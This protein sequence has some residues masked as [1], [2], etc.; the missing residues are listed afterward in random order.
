MRN[1]PN[2]R[3]RREPE[4]RDSRRPAPDARYDRRQAAGREEEIRR[5]RQK[6]RQM[7]AKHRR[8]EAAFRDAP[9][10]QRTPARPQPRGTM[11]RRLL[12]TGVVVAALLLVF[13]I[14][15]RVG[16]VNVIGNERYLAQTVLDA[17]GIEMGE[18]LLML[19]RFR[20]S[21]RILKE[22]PFVESV[23]IGIKLPDTVN[24][25]IVETQAA[26]CVRSTDGGWWL[27]NANGTLLQ[28]VTQQEGQAYLQVV[29]IQA[30]QPAAGKQ[31][32]AAET[33]VQPSVT[34]PTETAGTEPETEPETEPGTEPDVTAVP[35]ST[36]SQDTP[37]DSALQRTQAALLILQTLE[38]TDQGS[39][40]TEVDVSRLQ[41]LQVSYGDR[42]LV[43]LGG[44][45][46]LAYRTAYMISAVKELPD[47][48]TGILD[49]TFAQQE[50]AVF[51]PK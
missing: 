44:M 17:S 15:L 36:G 45:E 38:Q 47:Y 8:Q 16:Q 5:Q 31:I 42:V 24:I 34:Q 43:R 14:F 19:E 32:Q 20:I 48:Q 49:V 4:R 1:E 23:Q 3:R 2:S 37:A 35:E 40:V 11:L 22:L 27:M 51:Y 33:R 12:L 26:Y 46:N 10:R 7:Q 39:E 9:E 6:Q 21:A 28:S 25:S 50:A 13:A 41:D 18:N 30:E 29:G